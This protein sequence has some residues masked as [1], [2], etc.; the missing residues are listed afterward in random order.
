MTEEQRKV[1]EEAQK[2]YFSEHT[3][4]VDAVLKAEERI[5][6]NQEKELENIYTTKQ[7][8]DMDIYKLQN[9][10]VEEQKEERKAFTIA[11]KENLTEELLDEIQM[12]LNILDALGINIRQEV[13]D[14]NI[15]L[16]ERG[17]K[18]DKKVFEIK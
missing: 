16:K 7:S 4:C 1:V 14:H 5:K 11:D 6:Q 2:I 13:I 9:K 8:N 3:S 15:K 10:L 12:V 18:F 17:W